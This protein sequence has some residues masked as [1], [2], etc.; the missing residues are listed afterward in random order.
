[1]GTALAK[2]IGPETPEAGADADATDC[3][4]RLQLLSPKQLTALGALT[5]GLSDEQAAQRAHV[6][7]VTVTRWRLHDEVFREA[8][9]DRLREVWDASLTQLQAMLPRALETLHWAMECGDDKTRLKAAM[10]LLRLVS[11]GRRRAC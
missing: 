9:C 3:N 4:K 1:M 8:L 11:S 10:E 2:A 7:R 6:H 5:I